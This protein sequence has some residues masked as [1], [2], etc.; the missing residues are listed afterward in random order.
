MQYF[1]Q[2]IETM[3][4]EQ[5]QALQLEKLRALLSRI[6]GRNRFYTKKWKD[7]GIAP[8]DVRSLS[9]FANLPFTCKSEL[10]RAQ[11]EAPHLA[12]MPLS[13][14]SLIRAFTKLPERRAPRC[15]SWTRRKAGTGGDPAGQLC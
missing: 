7:A 3:P 2:V 13:R 5:L 15:G 9:D 8:G 1:N 4:R 11:M 10:E 6:A 14:R 12:R